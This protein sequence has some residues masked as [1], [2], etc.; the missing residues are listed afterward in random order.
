MNRNLLFLQYKKSVEEYE[1]AQKR[2]VFDKETLDEQAE[3]D[4][5]QAEREYEM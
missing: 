4:P 1:K 2:V 5:I 3:K